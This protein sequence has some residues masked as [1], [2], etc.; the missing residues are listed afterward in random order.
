MNKLFDT[1]PDNIKHKICLY[2]SHPVADLLKPHIAV[3]EQFRQYESARYELEPFKDHMRAHAIWFDET[4][5][6]HIRYRKT[7]SI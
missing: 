1:L 2:L 7:L 5:K 4:S 3:Y 6:A